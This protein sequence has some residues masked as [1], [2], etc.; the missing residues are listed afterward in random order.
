LYV[1]SPSPRL[2]A[3]AVRPPDHPL[4]DRRGLLGHEAAR[5][6]ALLRRGRWSIAAAAAL[7]REI[8]RQVERDGLGANPRRAVV[9]R[10]R[11]TLV[12]AR[13]AVR[14]GRM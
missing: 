13:L 7:Y 9:S 12:L 4:L 14:R 11:K 5:G 8:L 6:I 1:V 3:G 10:G 2:E